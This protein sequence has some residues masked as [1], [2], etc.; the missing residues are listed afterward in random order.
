MSNRTRQS[1]TVGEM[2]NLMAIDAQ[3]LLN[4]CITLYLVYTAPL[5][6]NLSLAHCIWCT[7]TAPMQVSLSLAL[8]YRFLGASVFAGFG[9]MLLLI[10]LNFVAAKQ[11]KKFQVQ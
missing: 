1:R 5:Q 3:R 2:V 10:P 4:V 6:V 8:L 11:G 9:A 7:C